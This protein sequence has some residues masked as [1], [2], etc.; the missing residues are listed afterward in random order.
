MF[1]TKII[2]DPIMYKYI[3]RYFSTISRKINCN[4]TTYTTYTMHYLV[5]IALIV[6]ANLASS[7]SADDC[8]YLA[9]NWAGTQLWG[10]YNMIMDI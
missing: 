2:C 5:G 7:T 10:K 9:G 1:A 6:V 8:T 4:S 3:G